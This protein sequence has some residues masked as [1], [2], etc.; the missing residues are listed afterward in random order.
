MLV[1]PGHV[2]VSSRT[3]PRP[4]RLLESAYPRLSE[5]P[6]SVSGPRVNRLCTF[7]STRRRGATVRRTTSLSAAGETVQEPIRG[8]AAVGCNRAG[9]EKEMLPVG[10][11]L[12]LRCA[13][14]PAGKSCR[15]PRGSLG[16][17]VLYI[18]RVRMQRRETQRRCLCCAG[19]SAGRRTRASSVVSKHKN[20]AASEDIILCQDPFVVVFTG[21]I[22]SQ[23][24]SFACAKWTFLLSLR[25]G[26][27]R[28]FFAAD[29][30]RFLSTLRALRD[31]CLGEEFVAKCFAC[32]RMKYFT[33]TAFP[34]LSSS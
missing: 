21:I 28:M 20:P 33:G 26:R 1:N 3:S 4:L 7:C 29:L 18:W 10:L 5:P 23:A 22:P 16:E 30:Q 27:V 15:Q 32:P 8:G 9:A 12:P 31:S 25:L 2:R 34:R 19:C 24:K 11:A 14:S 6:R 17:P 13:P